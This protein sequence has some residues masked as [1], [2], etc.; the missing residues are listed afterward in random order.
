MQPDVLFQSI[1]FHLTPATYVF[2]LEDILFLL[3]SFLVLVHLI[4]SN[5]WTHV[6]A[7]NF[8]SVL[9]I[10]VS[11][12]NGSDSNKDERLKAMQ[13]L[14][15]LRGER[16]GKPTVEV[17]DEKIDHRPHSFFQH[18]EDG[19]AT[20]QKVSSQEP[21]GW[22]ICWSRE[23][24]VVLP[25]M[26]WLRYD[27]ILFLMGSEWLILMRMLWYWP[28]SHCTLGP[29]FS[30][31]G[32]HCQPL[33]CLQKDD[34]ALKAFEKVMFRYGLLSNDNIW[35]CL[36]AAKGNGSAANE[37]SLW[38]IA[39]FHLHFH[40]RICA[41]SPWLILLCAVAPY[42]VVTSLGEPATNSLFGP[43]LLWVNSLQGYIFQ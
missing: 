29:V 6:C 11:Q 8:C 3:I 28:P 17:I 43:D 23:A 25:V 14:Q 40:F 24:F 41:L 33:C 20:F 10:C 4:S 18:L 5:V 19:D 22:H 15:A 35:C 34:A 7:E 12:F 2:N 1:W 31:A 32:L 27:C 13:F 39:L 26:F 21:H 42:T 9:M 30:I 16:N 36:W 38:T 37:L